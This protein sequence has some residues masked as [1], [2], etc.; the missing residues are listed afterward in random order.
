MQD[1]LGN[2]QS[3]YVSDGFSFVLDLERC[4]IEAAAIAGLTL[5]VNIG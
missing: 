1:R 3:Q 5:D 4:H 2:G